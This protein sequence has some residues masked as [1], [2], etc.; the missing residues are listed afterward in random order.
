[1]DRLKREYY[2]NK[3]GQNLFLHS[4]PK[5]LYERLKKK[6][7][8]KTIKDFLEQ[9]KIYTLFKQARGNDSQRNPYRVYS[10]DQ[11]WEC[12]LMFLP[13]LAK[14]NSDHAYILTC[15]DLFSLFAFV[16]SLRSKR[17]SEI[18]KSLADIFRTSGRV[19]GAIS[20]DEGGEFKNKQVLAYL[21][22]MN[23]Q[24]RIPK[25]TLN[26]K[27]SVI[28]RF[29]RNLQNLIKRY[30]YYREITH[31]PN[32]K[33]YIDFLDQIVNDYNHT[34]HSSIQ[35]APANVTKSNATQIYH[36]MRMKREQ[37]PVRHARIPVNSLVRLK[38]KLGTFDKGSQQ[39]KW[40][41]EIFIFH[42]IIHRKP[43]PVYVLKKMKSNREIGGKFY[44]R[45]LQLISTPNDTPVSV[46]QR[47]NIFENNRKVKTRTVG[48][49]TRF[50]DVS[51][52]RM[53]RNENNY[54]DV[55]NSIFF[56]AK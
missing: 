14:F 46:L 38:R 22:S 42:R 8:L 32:P 44:E 45:E 34:K 2:G 9:Q 56:D 17:P 48:G 20:H 53:Q 40:T 3:S 30:L 39:M 6:V 54:S 21:K 13:S 50:I 52:E 27:R 19:C 16:R 49:D 51:G 55:I 25:S 12:D 43:Y 10:I 23:I 26:A 28:E 41:R 35:T 33:R 24:Q 37:I 5:V 36:L 47:P 4:S 7:K 18:I 31:Q 15:I 1:M 29:N 11:C